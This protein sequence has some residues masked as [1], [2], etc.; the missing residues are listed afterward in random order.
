ML[1]KGECSR[2]QK[3]YFH[4][5]CYFI[6]GFFT[7]T[8]FTKVLSNVSQYELILVILLSQIHTMQRWFTVKHW[9]YVTFLKPLFCVQ[10][11]GDT[12]SEN[13]IQPLM[14]SSSCHFLQNLM[15]PLRRVCVSFGAPLGHSW[16]LPT[17]Y[18]VFT[19]LMVMYHYVDILW[20]ILVTPN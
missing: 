1:P 8:V 10:N 20:R 17:N 6:S 3:F 16:E 9:V 11:V 19:V 15:L 5:I 18:P 13:F 14:C 7:H 12:L 4:F 2:I